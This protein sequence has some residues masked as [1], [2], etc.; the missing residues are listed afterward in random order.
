MNKAQ[1][2]CVEAAV[3]RQAELVTIERRMMAASVHGGQ[4]PAKSDWQRKNRLRAELR[5]LEGLF[6]AFGV[7][8]GEEA[9]SA[10]REQRKQ[11]NDGNGR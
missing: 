6:E 2:A 5:A 11:R 4:G 3:K 7:T 10:D 1:R 8:R 9:R